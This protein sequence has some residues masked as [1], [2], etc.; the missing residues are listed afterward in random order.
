MPLIDSAGRTLTDPW[1]LIAD[2]E[3]A[4][5]SGPVLVSLQRWLAERERLL[6]HA[7]P[8][9]VLLRSGEDPG[10]IADDLHRLELVTLHFPK[11]TDGRPY[12]AARL[13]RQRYGYEGE[14]RA[15][16]AVLRDQL[17]FL[18]RCGFDSYL[19]ETDGSAGDF[20]SALR[21][22]TVSYQSAA[23]PAPRAADLRG[24]D[25]GGYE[26]SRICV[27]FWAY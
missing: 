9:G 16:G 27:G 23:D 25:R 19:L 1:R 10:A 14:L 6:R 3:E 22:L 8:L 12:S 7:G 11:F 20:G 4:P 2:N 17:Q 13:L 5:P 26:Q 18:M 24:T 21:E 15:A